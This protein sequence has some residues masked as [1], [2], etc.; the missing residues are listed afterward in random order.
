MRCNSANRRSGGF[1]LIAVIAGVFILSL[2][3]A[4]VLRVISTK[5]SIVFHAAAW[6]EAL[7]ASESG[8]DL[9]L[10]TARDALNDPTGTWANWTTANGISQRSF[11]TLKHGGNGTNTLMMSVSMEPLVVSDSGVEWYNV[12]SIGSALLSGPTRTDDKLDIKLRKLSFF[13]NSRTNVPVSQPLAERRIEILAHAKRRFSLSMVAK[14]RF[15]M[16]N[17]N[18]LI[19]SYDSDDSEASTDGL[20]DPDK[21]KDNGDIATKGSLIEAG[22][23]YIMGDAST[24]GGTIPDNVE[25][26]DNISGDIYNDFDDRL[27]PVDRPSWSS[28]NVLPVVNNTTTLSGGTTAEAPSRYKL[29]K[30]EIRGGDT[31]TLEGDSSDPPATRYFEIW[32][33]GDMIVSGNAEIVMPR[34]VK[35]DFYVEGNIDIGG[36]GITN[37]SQMPVNLNLYSVRPYDNNGPIPL[38]SLSARDIPSVK[39][40]GESSFYGA[41]YGPTADLGLGGGGSEDSQ[42]FGAFVAKTISMNGNVQVHYDEQLGEVGPIAD[43]EIVSWIEDDRGD[44]NF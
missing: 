13:Q 18:V 25:N 10:S 15:R 20:Y 29:T 24:N 32:V 5:P 1:T 34:G 30:L 14:E 3:A 21:A 37:V 35:V 11:P 44:R 12:R 8:I 4:H 43:Y 9:G 22:D 26:G 40:H 7:V 33:T 23:A 42:V 39:L 16:N 19:D 38:E 36:N 2:L 6:N 41:F 17:H 28:F 31:L 27:P